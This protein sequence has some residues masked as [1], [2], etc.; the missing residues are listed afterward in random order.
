MN[1]LAGG[2][3]GR[4]REGALQV[5]YW[6]AFIRYGGFGSFWCTVVW[7]G[8]LCMRLLGGGE[9]FVVCMGSNSFARTFRLEPLEPD[10]TF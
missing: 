4:G 3:Q 6:Y 10:E 5:H 1:S 7:R 9:R 2:G 8:L